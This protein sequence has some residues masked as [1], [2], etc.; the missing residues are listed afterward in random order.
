VDCGSERRFA[1]SGGC[2]VREGVKEKIDTQYFLTFASLCAP[3][4]HVFYSEEIGVV[5][6]NRA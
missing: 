5:R 3:R 6:L 4:A 2:K 1:R